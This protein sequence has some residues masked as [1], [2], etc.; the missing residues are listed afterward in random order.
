M[1]QHQLSY[2][3]TIADLQA[4]QSYMSRHLFARNRSAYLVALAGV[5]VCAVFLAAVIVVNAAPARFVGHN[6]NTFLVSYLTLIVLLLLGAIL[7]LMPMVRLRLK[8]LRMQVTS[9][10]PLV[11]PTQ[12]RMDADRL[13]IERRLMKTTYAWG[14]FRSVSIEKGAVILA[15]DNGV[16]V[17][18][19]ASAFPSDTER[20][21]LAATVSSRIGER[22]NSIVP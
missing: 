14:A 15:V 9:T 4:L 1:E 7:A 10:G 18:I 21:E 22:Q 6:G 16:G 5:V 12:I 17:I 2:E 19:P 8:T 3:T 20:F 13:T 11:G